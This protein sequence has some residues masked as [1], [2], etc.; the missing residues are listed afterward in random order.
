MIST[1]F[2]DADISIE[3]LVGEGDHVVNGQGVYVCI[4]DDCH[5]TGL[6]TERGW[7][8]ARPISTLIQIWLTERRR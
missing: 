5:W 4:A 3:T 1:G 7:D 8:Q 2:P 6:W